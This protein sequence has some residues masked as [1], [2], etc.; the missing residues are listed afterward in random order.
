MK[1]ITAKTVEGQT[2]ELSYDPNAAEG[3]HY[4]VDRRPVIQSPRRAGD[5]WELWV[6]RDEPGPPYDIYRISDEA[7]QHL[8]DALDVPAANTTADNAR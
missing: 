4:T 1:R 6:R 8:R 2:I 3:Q 7:L 5:A